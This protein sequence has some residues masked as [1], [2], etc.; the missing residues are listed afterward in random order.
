M[1]QE[2]NSEFRNL[3]NSNHLQWAVSTSALCSGRRH[4][5]CLCYTDS[6]GKSGRKSVQCLACNMSR[7]MRN[8]WW[9]VS[10]PYH[11]RSLPLLQIRPLN[12]NTAKY[13]YV[14]AWTRS[15]YRDLPLVRLHQIWSWFLSWEL[16]WCCWSSK[17]TLNLS[18]QLPAA[19]GQLDIY[20]HLKTSTKSNL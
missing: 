2:R 8:P 14:S 17:I 15:M 3:G 5:V 18:F 11:G 12:A 10:Q 1:I 6:L 16:T 4:G 7:N 19:H 20:H 9:I 13:T